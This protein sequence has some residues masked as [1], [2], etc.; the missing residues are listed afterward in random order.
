MPEVIPNVGQLCKV[1]GCQYDMFSKNSWIVDPG[2][3]CFIMYDDTNMHDVK[4]INK[5]IVWIS[6][7]VTAT[8]LGKI[9]GQV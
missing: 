8:K 1:D 6:R 9:L 2:A 5:Q 3:S 7:N 4:K